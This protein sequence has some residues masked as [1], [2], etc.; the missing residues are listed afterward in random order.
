[1][2]PVYQAWAILRRDYLLAR[3]SYL[4]L[5]WQAIAIAFATPTMYYLGQLV[6]PAAPLALRPFTGDYFAF[7]VLGVAFLSFLGTAMGACAAAVR[8]E[9]VA[10]TLDVL[11]TMPASLPVLAL[12]LSAWTMVVA[13]AQT[14]LYLTLGAAVFHLDFTHANVMSAAV[15]LALSLAAVA[16]LGVLSSAFVL[17]F[18]H[19]DPL[20]GILTSASVLLGGVFYPINVLPPHLQAIAKLLP[21]THAL[22]GLRLSL[23]RG[24]GLGALRGEILALV[25]FFAV[26]TPVALLAFRWALDE[27]RRSGTLSC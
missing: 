17:V 22:Q 14:T 25:A 13:A 15:I 10:G 5:A 21:V 20:V 12:G 16:V 26:V 24:A 6:R 18:K 9:Q 7:V 11:L 2:T 4:V 19:T 8:N 3:S 23:L 27:A 1:M